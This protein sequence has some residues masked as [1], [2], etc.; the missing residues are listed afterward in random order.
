MCSLTASLA[1]AARHD[2][3]RVGADAEKIPFW[4]DT[5]REMR[6]V[7]GYKTRYWAVRWALMV[8]RERDI[9]RGCASRE[10]GVMVS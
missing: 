5:L 3:A 2:Q 7:S 1:T 8:V 9:G 6:E 4:A 10:S